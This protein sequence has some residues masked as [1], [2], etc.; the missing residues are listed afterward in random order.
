[1]SFSEIIQSHHPF[2]LSLYV[3]WHKPDMLSFSLPA[4]RII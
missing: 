1:L 2:V 4:N 3:L